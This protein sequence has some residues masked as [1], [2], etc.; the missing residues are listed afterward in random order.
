MLTANC[1]ADPS[2]LWMKVRSSIQQST[3]GGSRLREQNALTVIPK[4]FPD[5]SR[6]VTTV[7]PEAKR[8]RTL[9]KVAGSSI[10][11][12]VRDV[13]ALAGGDRRSE[14]RATVRTSALPSR[15]LHQTVAPPRS[16]AKGPRSVEQ[17]RPSLPPADPPCPFAATAQR[18]RD[19]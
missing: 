15:L 3:S 9:R 13:Y 4:S 17:N 7:M 11:Y 2:T 8:P 16:P 1:D 18:P 5:S 19:S 6:T 12:R 14:A 10:E